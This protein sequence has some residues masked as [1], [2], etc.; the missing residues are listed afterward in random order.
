MKIKNKKIKFTIARKFG[1][2]RTP[3][4]KKVNP[5]R[6]IGHGRTPCTGPPRTCSWMASRST[7][8]WTF[9]Q[10]TPSSYVAAGAHQAMDR[11]SLGL[12][13]KLRSVNILRWEKNA[14]RI[15]GQLAVWAKRRFN[16]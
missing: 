9:V 10:S 2:G 16:V 15:G 7:G 14:V 1:T 3:C 6:K 11:S 12:G 8:S 4:K 5:M 13:K